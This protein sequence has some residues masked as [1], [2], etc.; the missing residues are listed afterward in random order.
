MYDSVFRDKGIFRFL[1]LP[2]EIRQQVY[3]CLHRMNP[4]KLTQLAPWYP[5]PVHQACVLNSIIMDAAALPC[6]ASYD[7]ALAALDSLQKQPSSRAWSTSG[8]G[9]H[10]TELSSS[11]V[12]QPS[13]SPHRP[14]AGLPT[15]L[16]LTNKQIYNECRE[17]PFKLNEFV[18]VNWFAS[19]L[20]GAR[21]FINNLQPWQTAGMRYVR[22]EVLAKDLSG[23]Y[24]AE[25]K[26]MCESWA[27]GLRGLRLQILDDGSAC[28]PSDGSGSGSGSGAMTSPDNRG[29]TRGIGQNLSV[30]SGNG[31]AQDWVSQSDGLGLLKGL[32]NLEIELCVPGWDD[33]AKL[34]WCRDLELVIN[35]E[36][37]E[38]MCVRVICV[39]KEK[40]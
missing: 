31:L 29:G 30:R 20:W 25:W 21:C 27:N 14:F 40:H 12:S 33:M 9:D 17:L 16:L 19:G 5:P 1:D 32:R 11:S 24:S 6:P 3:E 2:F 38:G 15:A 39:E 8:P 36:R 18:F 23:M 37:R 35:E 10:T 28:G 22:L 26:D 4:I 7:R 13:L 34:D